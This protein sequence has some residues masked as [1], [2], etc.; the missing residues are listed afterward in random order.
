MIIWQ[1][2]QQF[3]DFFCWSTS[4]IVAAKLIRSCINSEIAHLYVTIYR[5]NWYLYRFVCHIQINYK[6]LWSLLMLIG[7]FSKAISTIWNFFSFWNVCARFFI[8]LPLSLGRLL[9]LPISLSFYFCCRND[10]RKTSKV[11]TQCAHMHAIN[12]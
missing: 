10:I 3:Y 8:F 2:V 4:S 11:N 12:T 9:T 7:F 6:Y 5:T 1:S